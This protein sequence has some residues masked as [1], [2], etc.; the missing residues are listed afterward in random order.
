MLI[1]AGAGSID[2]YAAAIAAALGAERVD[3]VGGRPGSAELAETLGASV[4]G[5]EFPERLGPYPITVD[6]SGSHEGLAC[7]L[8]STEPDGICTSVG[9]Y[10]ERET[11]VPLLEM[12]T[13]GITFRTGRV[14]AA[15][16]M[17]EVLGLIADGRFDP[18]PVTRR[19]VEWDDA[20][21]ALAEHLEKLVFTR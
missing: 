9:I 20:P 8:R 16:A 17:P 2:L 15:P 13:K 4:V 1:C 10:Y 18:N 21:Q 6:A 7:A 19:F 12:Y 14:H 11:P 5:D 3:Y